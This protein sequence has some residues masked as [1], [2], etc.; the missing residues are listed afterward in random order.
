MKYTA[1]KAIPRIVT[2]LCLA[3]FINGCT[4]SA[5]SSPA[6]QSGGWS[7]KDLLAGPTEIVKSPF[8]LVT[9]P[10]RLT[11]KEIDGLSSSHRGTWSNIGT[12]ALIPFRAVVDGAFS[13]AGYLVGGAIDTVSGG[14]AGMVGSATGDEEPNSTVH[15]ALSGTSD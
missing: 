9:C 4:S 1:R 3:A 13:G 5:A 12:S 15:C 2:N 7:A 6:P 10:F 14:A 11:S 8:A